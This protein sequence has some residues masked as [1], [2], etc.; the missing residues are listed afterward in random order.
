MD[1]G[2]SK[3]IIPQHLLPEFWSSLNKFVPVVETT[4]VP[5]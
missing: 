5:F 3:K 2:C 1:D 4:F